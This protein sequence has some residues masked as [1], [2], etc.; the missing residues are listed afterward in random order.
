MQTVVETIYSSIAAILAIRPILS[1]AVSVAGDP[2][3]FL[4]KFQ[5]A[6]LFKIIRG[7]S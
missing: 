4:P 6:R 1:D 7:A 3:Q 2:S 5:Q